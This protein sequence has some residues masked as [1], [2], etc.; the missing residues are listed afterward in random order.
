MRDCKKDS[1]TV[2]VGEANGRIINKDEAGGRTRPHGPGNVVEKK[3]ESG[4]D[5]VQ[6]YENLMLRSLIRCW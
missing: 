5:G 6:E 2:V 4:E 1:L 3:P